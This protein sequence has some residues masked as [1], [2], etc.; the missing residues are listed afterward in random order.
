MISSSQ[1]QISCLLQDASLRPWL[2]HQI[3]FSSLSP[4]PQQH[5]VPLWPALTQI[6]LS[7]E[8]H[9]MVSAPFLIT[10]IS[11]SFILYCLLAEGYEQG[12][13]V[14][15]AERRIARISRFPP[16]YGVDVVR[17]IKN[18][19]PTREKWESRD[20]KMAN[21]AAHFMHRY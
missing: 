6:D 15:T 5:F 18:E 12:G 14:R 13:G 9:L 19:N 8:G 21:A 2:L 1:L 20:E 7:H 4:F 16:Y 10:I 3:S 17:T 11:G